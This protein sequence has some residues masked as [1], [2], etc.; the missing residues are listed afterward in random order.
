MITD[1]IK[2]LAAARAKVAQLEQSISAEL[3]SE[4]AALPAKF[5]FDSLAAFVSAVRAAGGKRRGRPAGKA[6]VAANAKGG[7][8]R[9]RA[10]ITDAMRAEV[11]KL[12]EAGKTGNE[13]AKAVGI[14]L[15][16]VHNIKK[17]LGLTGKKK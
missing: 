2:Q 1:S 14:S 16:S 10:T 4:L 7:K 5:G 17:Q 13:I 12:T 8:R 11:K 9:K 15:P 6:V 3:I